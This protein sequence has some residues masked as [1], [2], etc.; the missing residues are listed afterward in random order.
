MNTTDNTGRLVHVS[1]TVGDD[2][3][4]DGSL[5]CPV[6]SRH[7][8]KE[9]AG[10]EDL[11]CID[12]FVEARGLSTR[13]KVAVVVGLAAALWLLIVIAWHNPALALFVGG[14][15]V[16]LWACFGADLEREGLA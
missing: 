14:F 5:D 13:A 16:L 10:P 7:R 6:R 3:L 2:H 9:I 1:H 11:L 8:A 4:G 15:A 12:G